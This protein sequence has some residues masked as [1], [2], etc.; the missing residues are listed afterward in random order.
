MIY[1]INV[2]EEILN[3]FKDFEVHA[4]YDNFSLPTA[5]IVV[6]SN[7]ILIKD[8]DYDRISFGIIQLRRREKDS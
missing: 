3:K 2:S 7:M 1:T 8:A 5:I 6:N 4:Y